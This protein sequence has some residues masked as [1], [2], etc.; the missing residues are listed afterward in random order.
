MEPMSL[1]PKPALALKHWRLLST[2]SSKPRPNI[3][4]LF[5]GCQAEV[6]NVLAAAVMAAVRVETSETAPLRKAGLQ[7]IDQMYPI[8][9]HMSLSE[10]PRRA[11]APISCSRDDL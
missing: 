4:A 7:A 6:R 11:T 5:C 8:E 9:M 2:L 10:E 3:A 1:P